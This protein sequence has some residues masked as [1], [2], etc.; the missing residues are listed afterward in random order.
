MLLPGCPSQLETPS[1]GD[2]AM[3]LDHLER[4][5]DKALCAFPDA[6]QKSEQGVCISPKARALTRMVARAFDAY[7]LSKA[8]HCSEI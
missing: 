1:E 7:D 2:Q 8:G 3:M 6:L 5:F 4:L